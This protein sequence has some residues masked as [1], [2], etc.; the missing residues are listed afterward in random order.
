MNELALEKDTTKLTRV[1]S[2]LVN[3]TR[4]D[5]HN[6]YL[7]I[8]WP[9]S[10]D[11]LWMSPELMSVH[12]TRHAEDL[13]P[14]QLEVLGKWE[15]VN[16]FSLNVSGIRDLLVAM[17]ERLHS[18]GFEL[19]SEYLHCFVAEENEHMWYFAKFCN[20]YAGKLYTDRSMAL[21]EPAEPDISNFLIFARALIFE[22]LVDVYNRR[23]GEDAR[24]DPFI[25]EIN[26]LHHSDEV[27]HIAYGRMYVDLFH[28]QL[29]A[30]Y[31]RSR[32]DEIEVA[33]KR[34]IQL[35][36]LKL[37]SP[38]VYRDAGIDKPA[39]L[40]KSLIGDPVR[41]AYNESLM[42]PTAAWFEK[43]GIL[44]DANVWH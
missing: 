43:V 40:R 39:Q 26:R 3:L 15:C 34:F 18:P 38:S 13:S 29:R 11:G 25:Q 23:M 35:S 30:R 32:M 12:G 2:R 28:Q 24:L 41:I 22:E 16:F 10:V 19:V 9:E 5:P 1:M 27:R 31:P 8:A 6:P 37:Y 36:I 33:L 44:S 20:Q 42:A 4:S 17:T 21:A 7:D 14:A